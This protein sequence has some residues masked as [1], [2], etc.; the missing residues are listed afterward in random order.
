[1]CSENYLICAGNEEFHKEVYN[2]PY[3]TVIS[4]TIVMNGAKSNEEY[5]NTGEPKSTNEQKRRRRG[6]QESQ[7]TLKRRMK[8]QDKDKILTRNE[9]WNAEHDDNQNDDKT[10]G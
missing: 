4:S 8:R 7:E 10:G 1:M 6:R 5:N 3:V 9:D 2:I